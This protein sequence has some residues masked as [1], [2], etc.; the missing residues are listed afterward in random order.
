MK[1]ST[2][3][4][5]LLKVKLKLKSKSSS[6]GLLI[7]M[8]ILS[9]VWALLS[10]NVFSI[11]L[12]IACI[13][14]WLQFY[15]TKR[16]LTHLEIERWVNQTRAFTDQ[17]LTI[18][19]RIQSPFGDIDASISSH[20]TA[21]GFLTY[22]LFEKTLLIRKS[23]SVYVQS[24]ISFPTRGK[25][26]LSDFF[27]FYEHPINLFRHYACYS[28]KEE[29]LVLPKIM[30]IESFPSRLRELLPAER[31]EFK[32]LEDT[33]QIKGVREYFNEPLSKIHWK[34]SAKLGKLCVKELDY[35]AISN[36][37]LYLDLNLSSEIFARK[38]W[39]QIRKNYEEDA[40]IAT[41]SIIYLLAN[42]GN[43]ID[44]VVVG[45]EVLRRNYMV[46][47][48]WVSAVELL[49][50]AEGDEN[51]PQLPEEFFKDL[52]RLTP[53]NTILIISMYL[54]DTLLP[55]LIQAR[56]RCA[57]VIVLLIPYGFRD[58]R[59]KPAKTYEMYPLDM[60]KLIEKAKI[61]EKEQII[62]RIIR[63]NQSL[64]EV[65]DEIQRS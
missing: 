65:F 32:L 54:T 55:L 5:P 43:L 11:T 22:N 26:I 24:K 2:P 35:T 9:C 3:R 29:I 53:S 58:P 19:H 4:R 10:F 41:S 52:Y 37:V 34:I 31:S 15:D 13:F 38:V 36:T 56:T 1:Y 39:A 28:G 46:N 33:T 21:S 6:F 48:D 14:L 44:L 62:V 27:V 20:I 40:V 12:V 57:R 63:P 64:Q 17:D 16:K 47:S 51:G 49:A 8:S 18:N 45:K 50:K 30:Y 59:F 60:Q 7:F 25:K 61:L 23:E 42:R